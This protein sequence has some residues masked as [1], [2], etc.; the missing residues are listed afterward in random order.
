M[1][2]GQG[3]WVPYAV[4]GDADIGNGYIR[5]SDSLLQ[6]EQEQHISLDEMSSFDAQSRLT[7]PLLRHSCA[8]VALN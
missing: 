1:P 2:A 8:L 7:F 4:P 6:L 3:N 5:R